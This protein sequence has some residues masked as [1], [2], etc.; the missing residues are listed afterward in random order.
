MRGPWAAAGSEDRDGS[1]QAPETS[2]RF[3]RSQ[4]LGRTQDHAA[5]RAQ[6][7]SHTAGEV[8]AELAFESSCTHDFQ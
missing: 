6:K 1:E 7:Q 5:R 3:W 8:L 2:K 4:Q